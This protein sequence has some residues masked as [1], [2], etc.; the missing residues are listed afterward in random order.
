M[1]Y[2]L[3]H[4]GTQAPPPRQGSNPWGGL[5][6]GKHVSC[7]DIYFCLSEPVISL[8]KGNVTYLQSSLNYATDSF[9]F[10]NVGFRGDLFNF[11]GKNRFGH[12]CIDVCDFFVSFLDTNYETELRKLIWIIASVFEVLYRCLVMFCCHVFWKVGF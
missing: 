3:D 1:E 7:E 11:L 8:Y 6:S 10:P 9:P 2:P 5:I 12:R 4:Q